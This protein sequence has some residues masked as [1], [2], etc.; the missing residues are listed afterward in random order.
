MEGSGEQQGAT[1]RLMELHANTDTA[2]A[3]LE[4]GWDVAGLRLE[5]AWVAAETRLGEGG[6]AALDVSGMRRGHGRDMDMVLMWQDAAER[7]GMA[8]GKKV[9]K[10]NEQMWTHRAQRQGR[11]WDAAGTRR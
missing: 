10:R 11:G 3:R 6:D 8:L 1:E 9:T 5:R 2:L 4:R 7:S